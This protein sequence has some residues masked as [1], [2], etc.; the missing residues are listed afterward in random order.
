MKRVYNYLSYCICSFIPLY[1]FLLIYSFIKQDIE[2][3]VLIIILLILCF[4]GIIKQGLE[5]PTNVFVCSQKEIISV[6]KIDY[7]YLILSIILTFLIIHDKM[8]INIKLIIL[9]IVFFLLTTLKFKFKSYTLILL[10]YKVYNIRD[11]LI[12]SKKSYLELSLILKE[13][14]SLQ[15]IEISDNIYIEK[16]KYN[17]KNFYCK[18]Y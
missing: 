13:R 10:G 9:A 8:N 15:I 2:N 3:V 14:K 12:Y 18:D 7:I 5:E 16:E 1:I 4:I 6:K 17:L 11:K